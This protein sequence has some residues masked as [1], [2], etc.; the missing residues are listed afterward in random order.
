MASIALLEIGELLRE[1]I[2]A[3]ECEV[4]VDKSCSSFAEVM[5]A[6]AATAAA[7]VAA[8][9][10]GAAPA[11]AAA[12]AAAKAWRISF[13]D[14]VPVEVAPAAITSTLLLEAERLRAAADEM[15]CCCFCCCCCGC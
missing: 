14:A 1:V 10:G 13:G 11:A 2:S 7:A 9:I 15:D 5:P 8:S 4:V 6:A 12:A 3:V